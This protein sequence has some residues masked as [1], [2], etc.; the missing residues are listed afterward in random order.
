MLRNL[1]EKAKKRMSTTG[2][3]LETINIDLTTKQQE[4]F[5]VYDKDN[6][7]HLVTQQTMWEHMKK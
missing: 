2:R 5:I 1:I 3:T 4:T 6:N 7:P